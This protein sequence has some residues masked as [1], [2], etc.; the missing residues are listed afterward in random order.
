MSRAYSTGARA[1]LTG[2]ADVADLEA[3]GFSDAVMELVPSVVPV[4]RSPYNDM[5]SLL[6]MCEVEV[7]V[8]ERFDSSWCRL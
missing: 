7:V 8:A 4:F 1:Y 6:H 5:L 2:L 3:Q